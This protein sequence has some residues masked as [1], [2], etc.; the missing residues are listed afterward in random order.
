[1]S[2]DTQDSTPSHEQHRFVQKTPQPITVSDW[3]VFIIEGIEEVLFSV[4]KEWRFT[5]VNQHASRVLGRASGEL[6][7][8]VMWDAFPTL[9]GT[10]L[11]QLYRQSMA[12]GIPG[13]IENLSQTTRAWY[14][15]RAYP[16][17][18][19]LVIYF[20][21]ITLRKQAE[22]E[23]QRQAE[24]ARMQALL[25]L[26]L[27]K[28]LHDYNTTVDTAARLVAETI[29]DVCVIRLLSQTNGLFEL[30]AVANADPS[31]T[32]L[33]HELFAGYQVRPMSEDMSTSVMQTGQSLL[34]PFLSQEQIRAAISPETWDAFAP[35]PVFSM[36]MVPL[37]AANHIIGVIIVTRTTP[38]QPYTSDDQSLLQ[39]LADRV[40]LAITN[41]RLFRQTQ[42]ALMERIRSEQTLHESEAR[43]VGIVESA[44]DAIISV[45]ESL[46]VM[47]FN[48]AA[49]HMFGYA[50]VEVIG[51]PLDRFLP[52]HIRELHA[53]YIHAFGQTGVTNRT[54]GALG[55]LSALR[56]NGEAFPIEAAI[57]QT[58]AS[59]QRL[60]TV[61][62]RDITERERAEE[63]LRLTQMQLLQSQK[64]ES[65]GRFAGGIAHDFN[66]V[67]TAIIGFCDL[68]LEDLDS[69]NPIHTDIMEIRQAGRRTATLV[70][71]I[72]AFSRQ[73][74]LEP[75]VVNLNDTIEMIDKLLHRVIGEDIELVSLLTPDLDAVF[76]DPSQIEQ[77][78][79]NLAVNA[80]D[81]MPDG[82]QLTIETANV[83]LDEQY[84][85]AGHGAVKTGAYIMLAVSDTGS[86][87]DKVT[88]ERVF[89]PFFTTKEASKG[90]GLGLATVYGIVQQSGGYIWLYSELGVGTTF[91]IYFPRLDD[92]AL[93]VSR[94]LGDES[95]IVNL[96]VARNTIG[97]GWTVLLVEDDDLVRELVERVLRETGFGLIVASNGQE[98]F[99]LVTGESPHIDLVLTDIVMPQMGGATLA[100]LLKQQQ[101]DLKVVCMSGYTDQA[102]VRHG[103]L[104]PCDAFL[105]KP[106]TPTT[107]L[108]RII[109]V[110]QPPSEPNEVS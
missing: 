69:S 66:N 52:Q 71:Q 29:G 53:E 104:E 12:G 37:R 7:G 82:G 56:A 84:R 15:V 103:I 61:V 65:V 76:V 100:S 102:V 18:Q 75:R 58:V 46:R 4:D 94:H 79:M 44:M 67:L 31:Q 108:H 14:D 106:F 88:Q 49:E 42:T 63:A 95:V 36:L 2:Q 10:P 27:A 11:E 43:F 70:R 59:G 1:M 23:V 24:R 85:A 83:N 28:G 38:D 80:R 5:Y 89:D 39:D 8:V 13:H 97:Q 68:I 72:M 47:I 98:A 30:A 99:D 92:P 45:D 51:E 17:S 107:L 57:S 41:A 20:K 55:T 91:K 33:I 109:A 40:A 34:I 81:A 19:G 64:L 22:A 25:S 21:D 62:I 77:V 26:T 35:F 54:M 86:G 93:V 9:L 105:Q 96:E 16:I 73:Q 78:I 110:L 74:V 48:A 32:A 6:L 60:Y 87:M 90:T 101:P 50:A 3:P